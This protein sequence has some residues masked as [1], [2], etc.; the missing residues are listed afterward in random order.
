MIEKLDNHIV[1]KISETK[2]R[3]IIVKNWN[4]YL[5]IEED[6][7]KEHIKIV[8]DNLDKELPF[9]EGVTR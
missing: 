8:Q 9:K 2:D 7:S 6:F 1:C 5:H 3:V 4:G